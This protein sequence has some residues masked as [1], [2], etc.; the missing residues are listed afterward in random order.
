MRCVVST[1]A[2]MRGIELRRCRGTVQSA[3]Y[4]AEDDP[5][6]WDVTV[7][8]D[9]VLPRLRAHHDPEELGP[10]GAG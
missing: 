7:A 5:P 3:T 1:A 8:W 10:A 2:A 9:G 4:Y 6:G